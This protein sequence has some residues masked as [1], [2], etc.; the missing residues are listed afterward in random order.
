MIAKER[1]WKTDKDEVVAEGHKDASSLLCG[2]EQEVPKEY[3]SQ[4]DDGY[5]LNIKKETKAE[6]KKREAEEAAELQ[7][8][9]NNEKSQCMEKEKNE[10]KQAEEAANKEQTGEGNKDGLTVNK[11][12]G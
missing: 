10:E 1:L 7:E 9:E 8:K 11:K 6:K 2:K 12:Q 4:L 5:I 3:R